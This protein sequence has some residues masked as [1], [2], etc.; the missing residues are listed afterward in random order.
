[1]YIGK[2][3]LTLLL[4]VLGVHDLD[5]LAEL[6]TDFSASFNAIFSFSLISGIKYEELEKF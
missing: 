1:L 3:E 6:R 4:G 5:G 2:I